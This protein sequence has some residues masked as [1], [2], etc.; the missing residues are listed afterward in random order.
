MSDVNRREFLEGLLSNPKNS[1]SKYDI[2]QDEI[3]LK[4]TNKVAP[5]KLSKHRSGLSQYSGTWG[6]KQ[7][8]TS[9][10]V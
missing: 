1:E 6:E 3:F 9:F 4:Y 5:L 2:F 10:V 7:K 8:S